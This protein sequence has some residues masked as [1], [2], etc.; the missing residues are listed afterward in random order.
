[1]TH[2][3]KIRNTLQTTL[4]CSEYNDCSSSDC[5]NRYR[6]SSMGRYDSRDRRDNRD[7]RDSYRDPYDRRGPPPSHRGRDM[8]PPTNGRPRDH[9]MRGRS[10]RDRSPRDRSPPHGDPYGVRQDEYGRLVATS[11]EEEERYAAMRRDG[12]ENR[13]GQPAQYYDE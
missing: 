8:S 9:P 1:M 5:S 13:P 11:R 4:G 12:R 6:P 2:K 10:P 7:G 3:K